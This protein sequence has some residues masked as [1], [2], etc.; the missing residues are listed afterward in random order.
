MLTVSSFLSTLNRRLRLS[1]PLPHLRLTTLPAS[2][3]GP[4]KTRIST[5]SHLQSVSDD[6]TTSKVSY[7]R[8]EPYHIVHKLGHGASSTTWLARDE[9]L[10]K[11][12]AIKFAVLELGHPYESAILRILQDEKSLLIPEILDEFEVEGP[13]IQGVKRRHHCLVTKP[14]RMNISEA[15]EASFNKLFQPVVARAI[16]AQLI[17]AVASLHTQGIM[18]AGR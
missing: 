2:R 17:Y 12:V 8:Y 13:E 14:A 1:H 16:A 10:A 11:Y 9:N 5:C 7:A 6:S 3:R 18:H 4:I 15:R